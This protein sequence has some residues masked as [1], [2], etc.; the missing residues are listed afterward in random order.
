MGL[1]GIKS[2]ETFNKINYFI[3]SFTEKYLSNLIQFMMNM[4]ALNRVAWAFRQGKLIGKHTWEI[5]MPGT[6]V[7]DHEVAAA[8]YRKTDWISIP[9]SISR[10]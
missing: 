2:S 4:L 8:G 3:K 5:A 9:I 1:F 10:I 7:T 6:V